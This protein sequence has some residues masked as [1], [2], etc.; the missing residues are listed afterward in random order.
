MPTES[1][2]CTRCNVSR[3]RVRHAREYLIRGG[4]IVRSQGKGTFR[5]KSSSSSRE[6][7]N[8][9]IEG[10][11]RQQRDLGR[12]VKARV[13]GNRIVENADFASRLGID[14]QADLIELERLRRVGGNL[15]NY[16]CAYPS[17]ARFPE[18]LEHDFSDG[19]RYSFIEEQYD[20]RLARNEA[21]VRIENTDSRSLDT[22]IWIWAG[23]CWPWI[24]PSS[25]DLVR[26]WHS[27][28]LFNRLR[29]P[30]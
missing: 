22:F 20:V 13:L 18:I 30:K 9:H 21:V 24:P 5:L 11:W 10:F 8:G 6:V 15:H 29:I 16:I 26:W 25:T 14:A 23:S 12:T 7:I 4:L 28:W 17:V 27:A 1:G 19:S 3:I 2:L